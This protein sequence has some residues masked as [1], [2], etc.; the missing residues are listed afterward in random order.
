MIFVDGL[1]R[2]PVDE[3][4]SDDEHADTRARCARTASSRLWVPTAFTCIARVG[5]RH[6]EWTSAM[7]PQWK[8][9]DGF[10]AFERACE[11][12]GV[13]EIDA[14]PPDA[15]VL[16]HRDC[17]VRRAWPQAATRSWCSSR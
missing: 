1:G 4:R 5:A 3:R 2:R 16:R 6:A 11:I 15:I 7:P 13:E 8:I 14:V 9:A 10:S 12:V 17:P